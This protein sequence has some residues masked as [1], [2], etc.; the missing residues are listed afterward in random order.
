MNRLFF[1][2]NKYLPLATIFSFFVLSACGTDSG[3]ESEENPGRDSQTLSYSGPNA[4]TSDVINFKESLWDNIVD[5][6]RCGGCHNSLSENQSPLFADFSDVNDAYAAANQLID[7]DNPENSALVTK[8]A[9]GHNCWESGGESFCVSE[10]TKYITNWVN[11]ASASTN[12]IVLRAPEIRDPGS[13]KSFPDDTADFSSLIHTPIL[14][15]YC[16]EC[17]TEGNQTPF[18]ASADVDVAYDAAKTKID[19]ETPDNSQLVLRLEGFHNCWDGDCPTASQTMED[20]IIAFSDEIETTEVDPDMVTSKALTLVEDGLSANS[21]GRYETDVIALY[22][23]KTGDGYTAYDTSG[24]LPDLHLDLTGNVDWVGGWGI[25]IG[26]QTTDPIL[27]NG[28]AQGSTE[29]SQKLHDLIRDTGEYTLEAWV[30]PANVSQED[31]RIISY[32]GSETSRNLTLGQSLYNYEVLQRSSTTDQ[33]QKFSTADADERL[34]ASLQ[35][36]VVTF[37]PIEGRRIFVNGQFTEDMDPEEGGQFNTWD[38]SFAL[39]LGNETDG[40]SLWEGTFRMVAIHNKALTDEQVVQNYE[41]GVG[42]NFFLLF[43]VSHLIDTSDPD[44]ADDFIIFEVSQYDGYSYLFNAPRFVSLNEGAS[45][46][47]VPVQ[48]L[49]LGINGKEAAVGQAF[50]NV[51]I[52][53]EESEYDEEYGQVISSLGTTIAIEH[54]TGNSNDGEENSQV[55]E[56]FLSFEQI[57]TFSNVIVEGAIQDEVIPSDETPV[58]DI[59]LKTFD[60][61]NASMSTVTGISITNTNVAATYE[62]IK[63]QLPTGEFIKTFLSAHQMAITQLAIQYCDALVEDTSLRATYFSGFNFSTSANTVFDTTGKNLIIDNLLS[64]IVGSNLESQP[65]DSSIS[66]ELSD[67]IDRLTT[68]SS[69]SSCSSNR[70]E[71]VVKATCAAV[72]GSAVT[73]IQ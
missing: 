45:F 46:N 49:K 30:I 54:G 64:N 53:L 57:G 24:V 62:K 66:D 51:D 10:L 59:G 17:H 1:P 31:S 22:E 58:P 34:Q 27:N 18:I 28:K 15:V 11:G 26:A 29:D 12:E 63:Q 16:S 3:I 68:C 69:D 2:F 55:D 5:T 25:R 8:V 33:N 65:E 52:S 61:V 71:I 32:S 38:D 4:Q 73:L 40:S 35:H 41:V 72:L 48:G 39:V 42:E 60:E 21:G 37:D 47:G 56:F 50:K 23:F 44:T 6:K 13:S 20:A 67:L 43:S 19:L 14:R 70:T 36:V 9:D 7:R